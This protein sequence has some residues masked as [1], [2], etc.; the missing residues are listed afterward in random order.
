L[1][2]AFTLIELLV[3]VVIISII[4]GSV[5]V[6]LQGRQ[7]AYGL[8]AAGKDLAAALRFA[9]TQA[10]LRQTAHRI[11]FSVDRGGY[12]I[13]AQD[14]STLRYE[15]I[16]GVGGE[17][18]QLGPNVSLAAVVANGGGLDSRPANLDFSPDGRGF[19]GDVHLQ[20][21][22]GQTIRIE[23]IGETNQVNVCE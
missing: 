2:R 13:E 5:V 9:A 11:A 6:C 21:R 1:G 3:V 16:K 18:K 7:D 20:G 8:K 23:V 17:M 19:A 12:R 10:R 15:P 14:T 22:N 4:A